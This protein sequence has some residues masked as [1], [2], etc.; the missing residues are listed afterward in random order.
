MFNNEFS[1]ILLNKD[2]NVK[3]AIFN[4]FLFHLIK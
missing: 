4:I 2:K 3:S 1:E